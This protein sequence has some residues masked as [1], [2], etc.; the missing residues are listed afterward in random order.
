MLPTIS[1][2]QLFCFIVWTAVAFIN[3]V[4]SVKPIIVQV[5]QTHCQEVK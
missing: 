3:G 2:L 1:P 5:E 4:I